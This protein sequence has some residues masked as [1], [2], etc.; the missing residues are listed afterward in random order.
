[1]PVGWSVYAYLGFILRVWGSIDLDLA[2]A[3]F[4]GNRIFLT[5]L[6][7]VTLFIHFLHMIRQL[8]FDRGHWVNLIGPNF[9][10]IDKLFELAGLKRLNLVYHQACR[11]FGHLLPLLFVRTSFLQ[12]CL[13]KVFIL[14]LF[15]ILMVLRVKSI[16]RILIHRFILI[17]WVW[18]SAVVWSS[19]FWFLIVFGRSFVG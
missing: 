10:L 17:A 1:M 8:F 2:L 5:F 19:L 4:D 3:W 15:L 18:L 7:N 13:V 11:R 12:W 16:F 6:W 9:R 14:N